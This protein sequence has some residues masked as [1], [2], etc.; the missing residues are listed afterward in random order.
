MKWNRELAIVIPAKNEADT[1]PIL[2]EDL[3]AQ[4]YKPIRQTRVLIAD[5]GSTDGTQDAV[6]TYSGLLPVEIVP[7]GLPGEGRNIGA[8]RVRTRYILFLDADIR[9]GSNT[10]VRRAIEE[11][12]SRRRLLV[13]CY[14]QRL[15]GSW[16]D[17]VYYG[18]CNLIMWGSRF[19]G[20]FTPGAFMLYHR[21][22]FEKLGG[23]DEKAQFA[24]DYQLSRRIPGNRFG[25]IRG[26]VR[27]DNERFVKIG[28]FRMAFLFWQTMLLGHNDAYFRKDRG[29][30]G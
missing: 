25:L 4:D 27:A 21:K 9:L 1:L 16:V 2:L 20:P 18:F 24:E 6:R 17:T 8:R 10:I 19:T 26:P 15:G 11:A 22:A 7:G 13:G 23:F 30:W 12:K 14:F 28:Y 3:L 5:A 29:Y